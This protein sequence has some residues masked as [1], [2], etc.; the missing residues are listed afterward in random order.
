MRS[1]GVM[2]VL[3]LGALMVVVIHVGVTSM[4]V[5]L[6]MILV[7]TM[8]MVWMLVVMMFAPVLVVWVVVMVVT[9]VLVVVVV[10]VVRVVFVWVVVMSRLVV[11]MV[12]VVVVFLVVMV[13]MVVT[14]VVVFVLTALSMMILRVLVRPPNARQGLSSCDDRIG[15]AETQ[16]NSHIFQTAQEACRG[17]VATVSVDFFA[18]AEGHCM[19]NLFPAA[20][21]YVLGMQTQTVQGTANL[22]VAT[23]P[24]H[25]LLTGMC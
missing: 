12:V 24:S 5:M 14:V 6:N 8:V 10:L 9:V 22:L 18:A 19:P 20:R 3:V 16:V 25:V 17:P 21:G 13:V 2:L 11:V 15:T 4:F 1:M 7:F 23:M